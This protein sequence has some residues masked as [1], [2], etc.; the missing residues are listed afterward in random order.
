MQTI[1]YNI[2]IKVILWT[3]RIKASASSEGSACLHS[4]YDICDMDADEGG[5]RPTYRTSSLA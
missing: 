3:I 2:Q 1:S 5:F 4:I